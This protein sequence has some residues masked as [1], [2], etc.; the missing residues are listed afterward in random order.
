MPRKLDHPLRLARQ[1][2]DVTQTGLA[3]DIGV[4]RGAITA[5]EEGRN[6]MPKASTRDAIEQ[7]LGLE[8]GTLRADL[9]AWLA[10]EED[11]ALSVQARAV[12]QLSPTHVRHYPTFKAWREQIV[13][14]PTGFASLLRLN[15]GVLTRYEDGGNRDGMSDRLA[16]ALLNVL[17]IS[18]EYLA[19]LQSLSVGKTR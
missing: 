1:R 7:R 8:H 14:T 6:R 17:G 2:A 16:G 18:E 5:I 15:V 12:L 4:S 11:V 3:R 10:Q 19:A 13:D 9:L